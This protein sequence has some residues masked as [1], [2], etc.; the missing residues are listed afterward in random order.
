MEIQ[1]LAERVMLGLMKP[2]LKD[3]ESA[4][5]WSFSTQEEP[6]FWGA[7]WADRLVQSAFL[8]QA[9][10]GAHATAADLHRLSEAWRKWCAE[11][12]GR[13]VVVHGEILCRE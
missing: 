6:T 11:P 3:L 10:D 5:T 7:M 13:F 9:V 2:G 1:W 12:D 4:S 8:Q